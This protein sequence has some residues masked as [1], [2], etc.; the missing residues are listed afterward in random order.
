MAN[1]REQR[2]ITRVAIACQGGGSQTA[3]TAGV[4]DRILEDYAGQSGDRRWYE[5]IGF[6]GTSGGTICA[7]LAWYGFVTSG[8]ETARTLLRSFWEDNTSRLFWERWLDEWGS[9]TL[10]FLLW[11]MHMEL[12]TSPYEFSAQSAMDSWAALQAQ[13]A[14]WLG[15]RPEFVNMQRLLESHGIS[16]AQVSAISQIQKQL[17]AL[18]QVVTATHTLPAA[19]LGAEEGARVSYIHELAARVDEALNSVALSGPIRQRIRD[20][21]SALRHAGAIAGMW[22]V[23]KRD[24]FELPALPTLLLGAVEVLSGEFKAFDSRKGELDLPAVLAS[25]TLPQLAQAQ[26]VG[27]QIYWDGL[28]SQNAPTG[29]FVKDPDDP[30]KKPDQVWVIQINPTDRRDAPT[31]IDAIEDRRNELTGNISLNQELDAIGVVNKWLG[32]LDLVSRAKY[33]HIDVLRIALDPA[34]LPPTLELDYVSKLY[35]GQGFIEQ[36]M[37]HGRAQAEQRL[38]E[39][40]NRAMVRR[41]V[42][43][44]WNTQARAGV[45]R[46]FD[47]H[48]TFVYPEGATPEALVSSIAR[49]LAP[50]SAGSPG[51]HVTIDDLIAEGGTVAFRWTARSQEGV[52]DSARPLKVMGVWVS[53]IAR[54]A[55]ARSWVLDTRDVIATP[56]PI[57]AAASPAPE[58]AP[59]ESLP[60]EN[61]ELVRHWLEQGWN[62]ADGSPIASCFASDYVDH[63]YRYFPDSC[64][65]AD[66]HSWF[67]TGGAR[68]R[69]TIEKLIAEGDRVVALLRLPDGQRRAVIYRVAGGKIQEGWW[70]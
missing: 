65:R 57:A 46:H 64:D 1:G 12:K 54:G 22:D 25:T 38:P 4:L 58:G 41:L 68:P 49:A 5:L 51:V 13:W 34:R 15:P 69:L 7:F 27:N 8:P 17:E 44:G 66:Y 36:L 33:K 45:T 23:K 19:K 60:R 26:V 6:S 47:Q 70:I 29:D 14:P 21:M 10:R 20:E 32:K 50:D 24:G 30:R 35:R 11:P 56:R 40:F 48:H 67:V 53:E 52:G 16:F 3:F 61:R 42:E 59:L 55:F 63:D 28:F 43:E 39:A 2:P 18:D 9:R 37:R 31:L 62:K